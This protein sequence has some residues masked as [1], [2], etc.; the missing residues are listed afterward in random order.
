[1]NSAFSAIR[2]LSERG[3]WLLL[4]FWSA[5]LAM[6][7]TWP[8]VLAPSS[9][10]LGSVHADGMKHLWT[11]WWMRDAV[12]ERGRVPFHTDMINAPYGMD[13]FPIEPLNGVLAVG[14]PWVD[15]V[16]LANLLV[17]FNLIA[18]GVAGAWMGR[19]VS[20]TRLGGFVS[21]TLLQGSA[22]LAFFVHAGVGELLHVWWLP[23]GFGVLC[24]AREQVRPRWFFALAICLVG[25]MLSGF[26][27]GL[28]FA[29]GVA[30][31][32]LATLPQ[33]TQ[34][35]R[36]KLV[37]WYAI[38]ALL[39]VI[40]VVP[41]V[42]VFS[43][44]YAMGSV[45]D[46]SFWAYLWEN[47]G[48]PVTDPPSAR[49]ALGQLFTAGRELVG[50]QDQAYGGGRYVGWCALILVVVGMARRW[51]VGLPWLCV[52]GLG[53]VCA[54][55]TYVTGASGLVTTTE[56]L[57]LRM[58]MALFN[59]ALGYWAEPVNFPV[60]FM[61]L[62]MVAFSAMA[63]L[64][65]GTS[66]RARWLALLAPLAVVEVAWGQSTGWP[67]QSLV[68]RDTDGLAVMEGQEAGAV[69]DLSL[70]IHADHENRWNALATQ[71]T[72]GR[73]TQA[74]P[75]ERVE[76]FTRDGQRFVSALPLVQALGPL[77]EGQSSG[78]TDAFLSD[79]ALLKDAGF[80]F[81]M[82]AYRQGKNPLPKRFSDA[83][84]KLCGPPIATG[85]GLA[86]WRIPTVS[87]TEDELIQWRS[88]HA[89]RMDQSRNAGPHMGPQLR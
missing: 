75:L 60:R 61:A 67:W 57:P 26:Y 69:V 76:T 53:I 10:M 42:R 64:A 84:T 31:W 14:L 1:L 62:T 30:M 74:V 43:G 55:G 89:E 5:L 34:H 6:G 86:V 88:E 21:G 79:F 13:L 59:R 63:S 37:L 12:W 49:L 36:V 80:G 68:P 54:M 9:R 40:V 2:D 27:L 17:W 41:V 72:L 4:T 70:A 24:R 15:L 16:L 71:I 46:V 35:S 3:W 58:P 66:G 50:Q 20:G 23:L 11:L 7:L 33:R 38:T 32:A 18:T 51:R 8:I 65:V 73:A 78:V 56:G 28:F 19:V 77:Y 22:I 83:L 81:L 47:H 87:A 29:M 39:S 25:T 44:S 52:A 85:Q 45:P 82:A 48:Q